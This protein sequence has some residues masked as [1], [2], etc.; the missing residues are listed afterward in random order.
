[1]L[2]T[3]VLA[4]ALAAC[5]DPDAIAALQICDAYCGCESP[6]APRREAC[7]EACEEDLAGTPIPD[8]CVTCAHEAACSELDDCFDQ[9]FGTPEE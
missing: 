6:I 5:A 4:V 8:A 7:V 9:C 1:M 3:L 2:R